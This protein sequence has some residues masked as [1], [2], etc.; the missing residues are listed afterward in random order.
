MMKISI[1]DLAKIE[2]TKD[3]HTAFMKV[4]HKIEEMKAEKRKTMFAN[5]FKKKKK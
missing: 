1:E 5:F 3:E 2:L 4:L